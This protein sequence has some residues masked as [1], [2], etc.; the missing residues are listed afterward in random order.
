MRKWLQY[1]LFALL[2][3]NM[4]ITAQ[5]EQKH[6]NVT[7]TVG[8]QF[9]DNVLDTKIK[10]GYELH[11]SLFKKI[12][13]DEAIHATVFQR[14]PHLL[15]IVITGRSISTLERKSCQNYACMS[16]TAV[17][18]YDASALKSIDNYL[19]NT[20]ESLSIVEQRFNQLAWDEDQSIVHLE[21][22]QLDSFY[23]YILSIE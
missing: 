9:A 11:R 14:Y 10:L 15:K 7:E 21:K 16:Q 17:F 23:S 2:F 20:N 6:V 13:A 5:A 1:S 22:L 12:L 3:T 8:M 19:V 4:F 18:S